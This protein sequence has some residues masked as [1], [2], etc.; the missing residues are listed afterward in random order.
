[1]L[2]SDAE[3]QYNELKITGLLVV[4]PKGVHI[5][6]VRREIP[7]HMSIEYLS[8][9]WLSGATKKHAA[10]LERLLRHD[11][12]DGLAILSIN[13]D[14]VNTKNGFAYVMKFLNTFKTMMVIDES[15]RIKNTSAKR[16]KQIHSVTALTVSRRIASG[17]LVANS[18]L[19]LFG[20]YQ[21][22][23]N[24]LLGT[25]SFRAFTAEF[26][27]LLSP[28]HP[29]VQQIRS[30]ARGNP[31]IVKRDREGRPVY[32][33]LDKLRELMAPYTYR[34]TKEECLDLP[35]KIY[36]VHPFE[37]THSQRNLYNTVKE[38]KRF[39]RADGEIDLFSA[40]TMI[41]KL[42]QITS[43]FI[44]VDGK[45]TELSEAGP[46]MDA[47]K[48][49]VEDCEGKIIIWASFREELR[50]ISTMLM[51]YG[52]VEYHGGTKTKDR[53]I[54][55]DSFQNGEARIFVA[56]PAAGGVGLTLTAASTVIYYSCSYSLEERLQSEDRAHRIGTHHPVLYI[57]LVAV[58]TIDEKIAASLQ[59]KEEIASAILEGI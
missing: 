37:L 19:D 3:K 8:E 47:L 29:M 26:A 58:D 45:A 30:R 21:F 13:V 22:L 20:Q 12:V 16:T 17:T 54:A 50:Q 35:P 33:N 15:Q 57:D 42:R 51:E 43:G 49:I 6:W 32:R 18:P 48:E 27:E 39:L 38:E 41:N 52:V 24:G 11:P 34:V 31:Q 7:K 1:M 2:L 36:Q 28:N 40:L 44:L 4:A 25:R 59:S 10:R 9:F 46:R 23:Y 5:N 56:N 53:D 55:I 14:A